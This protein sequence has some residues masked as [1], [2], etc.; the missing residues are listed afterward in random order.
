MGS[1]LFLLL[2]LLLFCIIGLTKILKI[3]TRKFHLSISEFKKYFK[4][5]KKSKKIDFPEP[6]KC[7]VTARE[8]FVFLPHDIT[9]I[10]LDYLTSNYR[11]LISDDDTTFHSDQLLSK[12][13]FKH[14]TVYEPRYMLTK[15][16]AQILNAMKNLQSI[17]F[18]I[19]TFTSCFLLTWIPPE[20]VAF[21][22]CRTEPDN[23]VLTLPGV[24]YLDSNDHHTLSLDCPNLQE[25]CLSLD[26]KFKVIRTIP[27]V[28]IPFITIYHTWIDI[29]LKKTILL[30]PTNLRLLWSRLHAVVAP[31][32]SPVYEKSIVQLA[33][34]SSVKN[35]A[36]VSDL[37]HDKERQKI[38][39]YHDQPICLINALCQIGASQN[40]LEFIAVPIYMAT[41]QNLSPIIQAF[42]N[43]STK[44]TLCFYDPDQTAVVQSKE[45]LEKFDWGSITPMFIVKHSFDIL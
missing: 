38:K 40:N 37:T 15:H 21:K 7:Q 39:R 45:K 18:N 25:V 2:C 19:C 20:S 13:L 33:Q 35:L 8:T 29:I 1:N 4:N 22:F 17:E 36:I 26:V 10:V 9:S 5:Q 16:H 28:T 41:T 6:R 27:I 24:R 14:I 44:P 31:F 23:L 12:F 43:G 3:F 32:T 34:I 42:K 30:Q 11:E